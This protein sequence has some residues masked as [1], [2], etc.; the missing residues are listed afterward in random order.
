MAR[1][2]FCAYHS[3]LKSI[4]PL[5]DAERGRLFTACLEYSMSGTAPDLRGNERFVWPTIRE[6]IDRDAQKYSDFCK[7]QRDKIK[8]RWCTVE[9][10]GI[11]GI[12]DDTK[13]TKEKEKEKEKKKK[14]ENIIPQPPYFQNCTTVLQD[15]FAD[16]L[17]YKAERREAYKPIGLR[18]LITQVENKAAE[19][20][21]NAVAAL[22]RECMASNWKGIIFDRLG[23][24]T[25]QT[26]D[27]AAYG[28]GTF[29]KEGP[30]E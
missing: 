4:E 10:N 17:A 8:K 13:N 23:K 29:E 14:K 15:A 25:A 19:Y 18:N 3:Y 22:I 12:P 21:E 1:E 30:D 9:Y 7:A 26:G 5:N 2:Y 20:G 24:D 16:W 27:R 11:S 6:Q 28:W